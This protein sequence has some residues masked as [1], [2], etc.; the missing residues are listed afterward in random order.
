[1]HCRQFAST[2]AKIVLA[3]TGRSRRLTIRELIVRKLPGMQ[4]ELKAIP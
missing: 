2:A 3:I 4:M 1:M